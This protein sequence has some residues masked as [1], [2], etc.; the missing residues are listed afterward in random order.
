MTVREFPSIE[1]VR[2]VNLQSN[3]RHIRSCVGNV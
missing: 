1:A 2:W 3:G